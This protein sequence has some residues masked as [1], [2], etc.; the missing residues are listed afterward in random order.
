MQKRRNLG[1][2]ILALACMGG[3]AAGAPNPVTASHGWFRY[4]MAQ[5]PAGGFVA[6]HNH[7]ANPVTLNGVSAASCGMAMLH[8]SEDNSG[9]DR[10]VMVRSVAIPAHGRLRLKSGS[11]HV[12]CMQPTMRVGQT[13]PVIFHFSDAPDLT[14]PFK[15]YGADQRPTK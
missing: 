13:V 14:V 3:T 10:M 9:T 5:I 15:V 4:L 7:T 1:A 8:R 12:M 2:L 6:L 11:Y